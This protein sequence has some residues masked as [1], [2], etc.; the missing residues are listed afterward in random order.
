MRFLLRQNTEFARHRLSH[1]QTR[2]NSDAVAIRPPVEA[3][4]AHGVGQ[5][6]P[7]RLA[8]GLAAFAGGIV[9]VDV[10]AAAE[11]GQVL[12]AGVIQQSE[13]RFARAAAEPRRGGHSRQPRVTGG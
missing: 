1:N 9:A 2:R 10:G 6:R 5:Q 13:G 3:A 12:R 11:R 8:H 4:E 7:A